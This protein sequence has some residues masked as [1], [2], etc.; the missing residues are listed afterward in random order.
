MNK[1]SNTVYKNQ[2]KTQYGNYVYQPINIKSGGNSPYIQNKQPLSRNFSNAT[3]AHNP[4]Q[5]T[6]RR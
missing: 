3:L 5:T 4:S 1:K 6:I 2:M